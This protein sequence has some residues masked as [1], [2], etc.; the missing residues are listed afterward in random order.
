[1]ADLIRRNVQISEA[2]RIVYIGLFELCTRPLDILLHEQ[3]F[4]HSRELLGVCWARQ[5]ATQVVNG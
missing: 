5:S 3:Q 1:M 2:F 4:L